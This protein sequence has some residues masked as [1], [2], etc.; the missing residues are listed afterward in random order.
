MDGRISLGNLLVDLDGHLVWV[1]GQR[2]EL[3]HL[4]FRALVLLATRA[5]F[6]V[7]SRQLAEAL[8]GPAA[9]ERAPH[10]RGLISRLR[11]KL[12]GMHPWQIRTVTKRGYGLF[13]CQDEGRD[14]AAPPQVTA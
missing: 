1:G 7:P 6:V 13:P 11:R 5:S 12:H 2:V 4:E 3:T 10:L 14:P 8:W 9:D